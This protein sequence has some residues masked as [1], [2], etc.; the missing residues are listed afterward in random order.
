MSTTQSLQ[1][2]PF[3][4]AV[5]PDRSEVAV[6]PTGELDLAYADDVERETRQL[7]DVGF[8]RV[9]VDLRRVTFLDSTGLRV[10]MTLRDTAQRTGSTFKLIPGPPEV[11][12]IFEITG[13]RDLFTW[14]DY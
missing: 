11:Q 6:V 12:R 13:T 7:L 3:A 2:E 4:L 1:Y 9:V 14:R 5:V 10:L 8:D